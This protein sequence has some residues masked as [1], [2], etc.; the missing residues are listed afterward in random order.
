MRRKRAFTVAE[1]LTAGGSAVIV[2]GISIAAFFGTT[3]ASNLATK[4]H[5]ASKQ[6][7]KL[8]VVL[9]KDIEQAE[10]FEVVSPTNLKLTTKDLTTGAITLEEYKVTTTSPIRVQRFVNGTLDSLVNVNVVSAEFTKVN[11]SCLAYQLNFP[12][13]SAEPGVRYRGEVRLRNWI[14][15]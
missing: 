8:S 10:S 15:K 6:I 13:V 4:R 2:G 3:S 14:K 12:S 5:S 1:T 7:Y 11:D 9:R